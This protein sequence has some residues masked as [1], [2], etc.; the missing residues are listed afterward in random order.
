[1]KVKE[2]LIQEA[3]DYVVEYRCDMSKD[4]LLVYA[5]V[6]NIMTMQ[7]TEANL[8]TEIADIKDKQHGWSKDELLVFMTAQAKAQDVLYDELVQENKELKA[9]VAKLREE[10]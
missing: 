2:S 7:N 9:E 5:L 8:R 1:M 10:K 6:T 3:F 4:K